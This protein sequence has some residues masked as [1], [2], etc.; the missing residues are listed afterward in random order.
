MNNIKDFAIDEILKIYKNHSSD[1]EI[2]VDALGEIG[3]K[4]AIEEIL[5]IYKNH[6]NFRKTVLKLLLKQLNNETTL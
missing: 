5:K 6:S 1:R 4:R 3:G 2:V